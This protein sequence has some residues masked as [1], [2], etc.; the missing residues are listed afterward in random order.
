MGDFPFLEGPEVYFSSQF[1]VKAMT[2][3]LA[4]TIGLIAALVCLM[5]WRKGIFICILAGFLQ[6]PLRKLT[7]GE[8][9]YLSA[10]VVVFAALTFLSEKIRRRR[11]SL[12]DINL[13]NSGVRRPLQ[14]FMALVVIQSIMALFLTRSIVIAG[15]G[16]LAYLSPIPALLISY[17]YGRREGDIVKFMRFYLIISVVLIAGVYFSYL[18]Y[19]W[20]IL[21]SVGSGLIAYAPMGGQL[22]LH[23]GFLR[24]PET[25]AWHAG[26]ATCFM[27]LLFVT[28]RRKMAAGWI[29][30]LV[31]LLSVGAIILTGRRKALVEIVLF[32]TSYGFFLV[33]FKRGAVKLSI[34]F[35][36]VGVLFT[37]F[38][39]SYFFPDTVATGLQ[40][41]YQRSMSVREEAT[42]RLYN[43]T[44]GSFRWVVAQN[45]ILGSGAGMGSQGS[46]HFGLAGE[47]RVGGAAEGGL[48]K[49][50]AE[51]GIPGLVVFVWLTVGLARYLWNAMIQIKNHDPVKVRLMYGLI[52][53]LIANGVVYV[54]AHQVFGDP[55]VLLI[56]GWVLGFVLAI[57][58]FK[59][60]A[61]VQ[62]YVS[63][64]VKKNI[65]SH[66]NT[67]I[68]GQ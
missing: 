68:R 30:G 57:P 53:F 34:L 37:A 21:R 32:L 16:L 58:G 12:R 36:L 54:T 55:F 66:F 1:S 47:D 9:V 8:P 11:L 50:L 45:G 64:P 60:P 48:G 52:S 31:I 61:P 5:D 15:I 10:L 67:R 2:D 18:E 65:P 41:Y 46:Q 35:V 56:I 7:E 14:L 33:Y 20:K 62:A 59:G 51:L 63:A 44:I 3:I 27:V 39:N 25:A 29:S 6:D 26:T 4:L 40:P 43:M 13:W 22:K 28:S 49:I 19:D 17:Y 42:D 38:G 24:A 23:A